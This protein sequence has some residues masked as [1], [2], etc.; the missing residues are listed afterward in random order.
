MAPTQKES[1]A[2]LGY[3]VRDVV[4]FYPM[5]LILL[6]SLCVVGQARKTWQVH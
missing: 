2:G 1:K 4:L 6:K 3:G 5:D